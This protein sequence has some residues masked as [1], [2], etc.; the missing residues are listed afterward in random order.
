MDEFFGDIKDTF[1]MDDRLLGLKRW[2]EENGCSFEKRKNFAGES[3]ALK[4]MHLLKGKKAKRIRG[5]L[6]FV[7]DEFVIRIYDFIHYVS[8]RTSKMTVLE[9]MHPDFNFHH[10]MIRPRRGPKMLRKFFGKNHDRFQSVESFDKAYQ[11]ESDYY[12]QLENQL[13]VPSLEFIGEG[14]GKTFEGFEDLLLMAYSK[15]VIAIARFDEEIRYLRQLGRLLL[16]GDQL[17]DDL[18]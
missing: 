15:R 2:A 7:D 1:F 13:S 18:V 17:D 5:I 8:G 4:G 6:R 10:F 11:L 3:T 14:E 9:L 12:E 16:E